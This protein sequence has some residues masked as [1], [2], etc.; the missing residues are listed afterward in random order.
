ML[1]VGELVP[2]SPFPVDREKGTFKQDPSNL[3]WVPCYAG[4]IWG[5]A[6]C[7]AGDHKGKAGMPAVMEM[8]VSSQVAPTSSLPQAGNKTGAT[9]LVL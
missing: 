7:P 4:V 8:P 1:A 9:S 6:D 3:L 2:L 5:T